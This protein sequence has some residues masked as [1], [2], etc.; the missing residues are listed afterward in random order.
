MILSMNIHNQLV[1][2]DPN[3]NFRP[4]IMRKGKLKKIITRED[5]LKGF[6]I[7][8]PKIL[9]KWKI[10]PSEEDDESVDSFVRRNF[11][12][13]RDHADALCLNGYQSHSNISMRSC[14]PH[15]WVKGQMN[16][17]IL[18]FLH[19]IEPLRMSPISDVAIS[20]DHPI[21]SEVASA[22]SRYSLKGG[23]YELIDSLV[24]DLDGRVELNLDSKL[25]S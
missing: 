25:I 18:R 23:V 9:Q 5:L 12:W 19:K 11:G 1:Y 22:H 2:S 14:F 8:F 17:S 7:G 15:I 20:K 3:Y 24:E 13:G 10:P 4:L 6:F 21:W 16:S